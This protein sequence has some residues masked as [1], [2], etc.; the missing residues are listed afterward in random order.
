MHLLVREI[1]SLD[2]QAQ[3]E[4]LGHE[5]ADIIFLS[6]SDSDLKNIAHCLTQLEDSFPSV[7]LAPL[8]R[9]RHPMSVD[10]YIEEIISN[11]HCV[12][13]R[14]LGGLEYWRYGTQEVAAICREKNIPL[15]ILPGDHREDTK[16]NELST[17]NS[18]LLTR[19]K[20]FFREGG[21]SNLTH[22]LRLAA[23]LAG[24]GHDQGWQA[25]ALPMMGE[26]HF[27]SSEHP[28]D[29]TALIIFY[30]THLL[31]GDIAPIEA[32]AEALCKRK[33]NVRGIY[34]S[35]LKDP[36]IAHWISQVLKKNPP[37]IILNTTCF[38]AQQDNQGTPLDIAQVPVLQL[39]QPNSTQT[40]WEKTFRGISQSDLAMQ[41]V[42]PELDGRLLTT[43]ISFKQNQQD[44]AY[45]LPYLLGIELVADRAKGWID[46]ATTPNPDKKIAVILSDYPGVGGQEGHAVGLDSFASLQKI[47]QWLQKE[48]YTIEKAI[49][50]PQELAETLCH[51][52]PQ[53]IL[54]LKLY[55]QLFEN[56]PKTFQETVLKRWPDMEK[57]ESFKDGAFTLRY[58]QYGHITLAI[59]PD[60]STADTHKI[61]YHDPDTPPAHGYIATYL[62]LRSIQSI[63]AMIHLGTHGTLEWLPG[64]AA[65]LS[66]NC[67]PVVLLRGMP[68]IYPFIVNN[69]GEAAC[70]K[71]RLGAVTI[72][73]LTPPVSK[74]VLHG[75][76]AELERLI[77]D[78]AEADG[79]DQRRSKIL[80]GTIL[81]KAEACGLLAENGIDR[82]QSGDEVALSR[83]D[84]YLCDV[85][86]LQIREGL[87][88]FGTPPIQRTQL[89]KTI[90]AYDPEKSD[91]I[92]RQ[93]DECAHS[94]KHALLTALCG[95]FVPP[96]PAGAP[97]R[98]CVAVLPTGRNL[99][100]VD[101]RAIPTQTAY[102]LAEKAAEKLLTQYMQENGDHLRHLVIDLWGSTSLRTGGEDLALAYILMGTR[103]IWDKGSGRI[104]GVEILPIALLDRPRVDV[105]LRISGLFRDAFEAQIT[106]FDQTV[107]AVAAQDEDAEWNILASHIKTLEKDAREKALIRVYGSAPGTYGTGIEEQLATGN[108]NNRD[109]LGKEWLQKSSYAYGNQYQGICDEAGFAERIKKAQALLHSQD[110]AEID[111]LDSPDYAAHEGGFAA[112]AKT[113]DNRPALYHMDTSKPETPRIRLLA[114]EIARIVRGRTANPDWIY[115]MMNH[116]Y[117]GAAEI[118]RNIDT[119][120]SFAATLPQRFDKQFD[121]VFHATLEDEKVR[122]FLETANPAAMHTI[123]K[124]FKEACDRGLWHPR[125]NSISFL[126]KE[127]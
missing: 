110:H 98:G 28:N 31:A 58:R 111:L 70:A 49:S 127:L 73:H 97:T 124:R 104:T 85:K 20:S 118:A 113:L 86:D 78:Y 47:L 44:Y 99:Y 16:L 14:L 37:R 121:L 6:F 8:T 64:K 62:W 116:H 53:P 106:M 92:A 114:E 32:L 3:A 101:P 45:Y 56:L 50:S 95:G 72:G 68:V 66:E 117:R 5:P 24:Y 39:I 69:P 115:S 122:N 41:V 80:L 88:V 19:F 63:H 30:R 77:D 89:L 7:R 71:R 38:S 105:T 22:A 17:V 74:A 46:L 61:L 21:I 23:H 79:L 26:Y 52:E 65:A 109:E 34:V 96:G 57:D 54:T 81:D 103:P 108:W 48:N 29:P 25:E 43:A 27:S 9:L 107:H 84:S 90:Q 112:A 4:D 120:F 93:L 126:L 125:S 40:L 33:I 51:S 42:L 18:D 94:E 100:T 15:I 102:L 83:L 67:A 36:V 87:H 55:R 75:A 35:S 12:I 59:Q 123:Q 11:A 10:I 119:L 2:E 1:R 60:R 91:Q 76:A 82:R 13:L